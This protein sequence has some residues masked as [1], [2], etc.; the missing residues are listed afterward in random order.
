MIIWITGL[1]GSG[2]TTLSEAI[3]KQ[4]KAKV[5]ELFFL[6]G[7]VIRKVFQDELGYTEHERYKQ[8][9]RI[10]SIAKILDK[11]DLIVIVAAL[12]SHPDL[13]AWNRDNFLQY[14]EIYIDAPIHIVKHRDPKGLYAKQARGEMSNVVGID[15]PWH[16]P[17][18]S[19]L[20]LDASLGHSIS[21]M[22]QSIIKSVPR[23][24]SVFKDLNEE[25]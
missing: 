8:I 11:Q 14:Y 24:E 19:D 21:E 25:K 17:L 1:S 9:V 12:Y 22:A 15:V 20:I 3:Y 7:D 16:I 13:L 4:L 2:K 6:D 18:K 5:P 10:Q 23:L